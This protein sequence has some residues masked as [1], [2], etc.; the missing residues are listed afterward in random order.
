MPSQVTNY[1]C[2]SCN[3]PLHYLAGSDKLKCDYCGSEFS[4]HEIE[5]LYSEKD[6]AAVSA[7]LKEEEKVEVQKDGWDFSSISGDWASEDKNL[8][9]Y[10]CPSCGAELLCDDTTAATSCPYCGNPTIV[11]GQLTGM[12]KPDYVIPFRYE[13]KAAVEALKNYYKGKYFL[14]KTFHDENHIDEIKG[15]YAPF[16]LYDGQISA[17]ITYHATRSSTYRTGDEEITTTDHY[18]IRR[19]GTV[20][21]EHVPADASSKLPDPHMDSIEPYDYSELKPFSTGYLPGYLADKYDIEALDQIERVA[22]R[23]KTTVRN[24]IDKTVMGYTTVTPQSERYRVIPG[25]VHYALL[26]VWL[27]VTNWN[28]NRYVFAMNGQTGKM[29]GDLPVDKGRFWLTTLLGGA[30]VAAAVFLMSLFL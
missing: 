23:E 12:L 16:W 2:P 1:Q 25:V 20:S 22:R 17:D 10:N 26:P 24:E 19:G 27:L 4:I 21:F 29:I 7:Q 13:K 14:P 6:A 8:R 18:T 15:I 28:G 30:G 11:P 3:G 9:L 5:N